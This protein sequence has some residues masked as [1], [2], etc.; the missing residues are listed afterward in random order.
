MTAL[1]VCLLLALVAGVV[2]LAV[3]RLNAARYE[4]RARSARL[5][6]AWRVM[7][8]VNRINAAHWRACQMMRAEAERH[9][10]WDSFS[11]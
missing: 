2:A 8:A 7:Q 11:S 6:D 9:Q 5:T 10:G 1:V 4:R 3:V